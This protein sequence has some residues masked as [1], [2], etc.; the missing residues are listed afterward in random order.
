M[1][2]TEAGDEDGEPNDEGDRAFQEAM[3]DKHCDQMIEHF[4][5]VIIIATRYNTTTGTASMVKR[6]RGNY[7]SQS[8]MVR[9][10]VKPQAAKIF[11]EK[12]PEED[13]LSRGRRLPTSNANRRP[14]PS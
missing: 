7:S 11:Y 9:E 1:S 3:L 10:W 4:D 5:A 6:G 14:F 2:Q 8:G 12:K 13:Y